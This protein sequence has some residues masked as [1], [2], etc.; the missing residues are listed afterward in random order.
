MLHMHGKSAPAAQAVASETIHDLQVQQDAAQAHRLQDYFDQVDRA[1]A[2]ESDENLDDSTPVTSPLP[3]EPSV[4]IRPTPAP[5]YQPP[6][7]SGWGCG[8]A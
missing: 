4:F 6:T 8:Y 7:L 1:Q 3:P 5:T 2:A